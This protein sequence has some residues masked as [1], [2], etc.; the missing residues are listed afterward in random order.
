MS[1]VARKGTSVVVIDNFNRHDPDS[2]FQIFGFDD[3]DHAMT[4]GTRRVRSSIEQFR[5]PDQTQEQLYRKWMAL[6]EE[7]LV[8]G[9]RLGLANFERFAAENATAEE[10]DYLSIAPDDPII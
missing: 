8:E 9:A 3:R 4:Y 6:G 1:M 2:K 10:C 5:E 7:V